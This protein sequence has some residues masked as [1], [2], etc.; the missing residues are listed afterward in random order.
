MSNFADFNMGVY[1]GGLFGEKPAFPFTYAEFESLAQE[2]LDSI[3]FDYVAGG[4]GN[5]ATQRGNVEALERIG[6]R[7][8]ILPAPDR[9]QTG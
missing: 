5:E 4:A 1:V 2:K 8:R 6:Y 9:K 7:L 3:T